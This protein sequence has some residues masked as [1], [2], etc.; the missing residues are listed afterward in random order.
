VLDDQIERLRELTFDLTDELEKLF[1]FE[2][3]LKLPSVPDKIDFYR[4]VRRFE[5]FLI[6]WALKRMAGSQVRASNL[7][8]LD[9]TTLNKK[10]KAYKISR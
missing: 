3:P 8:K 5:I 6:K 10:I 4:E 2:A 1:Q 7:L 9:S